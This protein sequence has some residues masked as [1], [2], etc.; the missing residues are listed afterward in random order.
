MEVITTFVP[1]GGAV[2]SITLSRTGPEDDGPLLKLHT[3]F[4]GRLESNE[5]WLRYNGKSDGKGDFTIQLPDYR[6]VE[7]DVE[8]R[9]R[10]ECAS[11]ERGEK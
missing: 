3:L 1:S 2:D 7:A 4:H 10:A 6:A 8:A 5:L 9:V 11:R